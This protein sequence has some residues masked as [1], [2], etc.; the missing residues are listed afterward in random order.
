MLF[1][2]LHF[3]W[4][5]LLSSL[6]SVIVILIG[7]S[8]IQDQ[9]I[10]CPEAHLFCKSCAN[11]YASTRLSEHNLDIVCMDQSGCKVA[12]TV[13]ELRRFLTPKLMDLYDRMKQNKEIEAAKLEN[14]ES[15][16]FCEYKVVIDDLDEELFQCENADCSV[17]SCRRRKKV[18]GG[19]SFISVGLEITSAM[20][21]VTHQEVVKVGYFWSSLNTILRRL[22]RWKKTNIWMDDMSSR[23]Q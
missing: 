15:C 8:F 13:S 21:R 16:P 4:F 7:L 17:V 6:T 1:F 18:V 23:K 14:L 22:Q 19:I 2:H 3:C 9:I 12:F 20:V 11:S 10:Q 5:F